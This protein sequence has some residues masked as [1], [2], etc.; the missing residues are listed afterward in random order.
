MVRVKAKGRFSWFNV[1]L[2]EL[3]SNNPISTVIYFTDTKLGDKL[4][5]LESVYDVLCPLTQFPRLLDVV[6]IN[7]NRPVNRNDC[8]SFNFKMPGLRFFPTEF[9]RNGLEIPKESS[10]EMRNSV[11]NALVPVKLKK[12]GSP[13]FDPILATDSV[14]SLFK[15]AACK[16]IHYI[17]LVDQSEPGSTVGRDTVFAL[18]NRESILVR[19]V[20]NASFF[21]NFNLKFLR[22]ENKLAIIPRSRK[23]LRLYPRR[24]SGRAYAQTVNKFLDDFN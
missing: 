14:A 5:G 4:D 16:C 15:Q 8:S 13:N 19:I 22:R 10:Y 2:S 9:K 6:L 18:L 11:M 7:C 20:N 17:V 12:P 24:A 1:T 3:V 21:E 23:A